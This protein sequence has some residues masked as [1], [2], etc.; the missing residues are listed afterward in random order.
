METLPHFES[1]AI[2][3]MKFMRQKKGIWTKTKQLELVKKNLE[4]WFNLEPTAQM[5]Y[6]VEI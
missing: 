6:N 3:L 1:I 5:K 2:N 4:L